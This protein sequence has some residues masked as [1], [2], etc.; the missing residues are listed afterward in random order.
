M[1]TNRDRLLA[2]FGAE[3]D[4][5]IQQEAKPFVARLGA[6][7]SGVWECKVNGR[8][9]DRPAVASNEFAFSA[10]GPS[11]GDEVILITSESH[12]TPTIIGVSPW[13]IG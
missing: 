8:A 3:A 11:E 4:A 6:E 10:Q 13:I 1:P 7:T 5:A 12:D 9:Y 2:R